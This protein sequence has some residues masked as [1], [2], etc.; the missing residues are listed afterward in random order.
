MHMFRKTVIASIP[1]LNYETPEAALNKNSGLRDSVGKFVASGGLIPNK[2]N[3]P[4]MC[5]VIL[6]FVGAGAGG[7]WFGD[8]NCETTTSSS[9]ECLNVCTIRTDIGYEKSSTVAVDIVSVRSQTSAG[10]WGEDV[11]IDGRLLQMLRDVKETN[12]SKYPTHSRWNFERESHLIGDVDTEDESCAKAHI[13]DF[14]NRFVDA[15]GKLNPYNIV[16]TNRYVL[17]FWDKDFTHRME[18]QKPLA[19]ITEPN[20]NWMIMYYPENSTSLI[21][22]L[23]ENPNDFNAA[24][25]ALRSKA[26]GDGHHVNMY[27][28]TTAEA[29]GTKKFTIKGDYIPFHSKLTNCGEQGLE[30]RAEIEIISWTL[31]K[32]LRSLTPE[33]KTDTKLPCV[34][35]AWATPGTN[36]PGLCN[37]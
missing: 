34:E 2:H 21:Q 27:G 26:D 10:S 31:S 12:T 3:W 36:L 23:A 14:D 28:T 30:N 18:Y 4:W 6:A 13:P 5:L 7:Y 19:Q 24:L 17:L 35:R 37:V 20:I 11:D 25:T 33:L 16:D 8:D 15:H 22:A 29:G 9:T 32:D 1:I